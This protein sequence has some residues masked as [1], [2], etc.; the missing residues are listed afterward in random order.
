MYEGKIISRKFSFSESDIQDISSDKRSVLLRSRLV[1]LSQFD[2]LRIDGLIWISAA[3]IVITLYI[4]MPVRKKGG[5][6][7]EK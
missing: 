4:N 6:L 5:H 7:Y 3:L 1:S 2:G